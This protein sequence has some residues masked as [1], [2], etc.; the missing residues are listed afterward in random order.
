MRGD[1]VLCRGACA[2]ECLPISR[3]S[4]ICEV[5]YACASKCPKSIIGQIDLATCKIADS[6]ALSAC[7]D[8]K[9]FARC[10]DCKAKIPK[11]GILIPG[12]DPGFSIL[13]PWGSNHAV[14]QGDLRVDFEIK[15]TAASVGP[16][17]VR[18][19]TEGSW[20]PSR[21]DVALNFE[22]EA[23]LNLFDRVSPVMEQANA[24]DRGNSVSERYSLTE[25]TLEA[26]INNG[27]RGI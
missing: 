8:R 11:F 26:D 14:V 20:E 4:K 19:K 27:H 22:R 2:R 9:T 17:Q 12:L 18:L 23:Q 10:F 3:A 21:G 5:N 6:S 1:G 16:A 13:T 24:Y 25:N 7:Q 15:V